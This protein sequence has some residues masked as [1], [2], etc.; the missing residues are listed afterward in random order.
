M[1]GNTRIIAT[2]NELLADEL[3]AINQYMVHAE[4]CESWGLGKFAKFVEERAV[5]EMKHAEKLIKRI[6][7]LEGMPVVSQLNKISIGSDV[8]K[9]LDN[10][11]ALELIAV[12]HYNKAI[13]EAADLNDNATAQLFQDILM[14]EDADLAEIEEKLAQINQIGLQNFLTLQVG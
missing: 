11:L 8:R 13:K 6:L 12:E 4:M 3:T 9:Q 1:K 7:F 10:D 2:L 5:S 14:E